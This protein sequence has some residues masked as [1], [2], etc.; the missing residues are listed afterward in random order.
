MRG[1]RETGGACADRAPH[2]PSLYL[3][4]D[5][6]PHA[7]ELRGCTELGA[8]V[9][10]VMPGWRAVRMSGLP[11]GPTTLTRLGG[12]ANGSYTYH[13]HWAGRPLERQ[14]QAGA[15]CGAVADLV[16][17]Y[18]D[19]RPGTFGLHCGAVRIGGHLVAFT[20]SY[21]AG[22]TTLVTRLGLE[23]ECALFC[24]DVLPIRPDGQ[25]VALGIQPR[26][27]LPLPD[28]LS[29]RFRTRLLRAFTVR[30]ARYGYVRL[31]RQV[32]L[33]EAAPVAALV[34]LA[35]RAGARARLHHLPGSEAAACLI[36]QNIADP[37][38]TP[39][40]YDRVSAMVD[41]L[42]CVK[43]VYS[44]IEEAVALIRR[45]FKA[46]SVPAPGTRIEAPTSPD[47]PEV[48]ATPADPAGRFVR[49]AE[50]LER[51][52]GTDTFLWQTET[53]NWFSLNPAGAVIW[54]LLEAPHSGHELC[55]VLSEAFPQADPDL[56]ARDIAVLLGQMAARNLVMALP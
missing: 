12:T 5:E 16:Q 1:H 26:V 20:G 29:P 44:D 13:S 18:C 55:S 19:A 7:I 28:G 47:L 21:R 25:A 31:A 49:S 36:R 17:A 11:A 3:G 30:D 51:Q 34:L 27:R 41:A 22:K 46:P 14:G 50:V 52:I 23:R 54:A 2:L 42:F 35:R 40:H 38:E 10:T 24:D 45:A 6:A 48:H 56:I 8:A 53:R 4:F 43:L 33:G 37:G 32:G 9:M 39:A 15:V